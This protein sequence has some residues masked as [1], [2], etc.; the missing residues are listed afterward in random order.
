MALRLESRQQAHAPSTSA[1]TDETLP[2]GIGRMAVRAITASMSASC[3]IEHAGGYR[4]CSDCKDSNRSKELVEVSRRNDQP[5]G[6]EDR[7]QHH[8]RFHQREEVREAVRG[9]RVS[10][11]RGGREINPWGR[12]H[13]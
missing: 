11:S 6:R 10:A 9:R 5:E 7:K 2:R 13:A 4:P 8:A 12:L 1:S 3:H